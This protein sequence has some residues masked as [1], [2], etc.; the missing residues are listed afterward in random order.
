MTLTL[1]EAIG[2]VPHW[3]AAKAIKTTPLGGGITNRNYRV[4]VDGESFV[5][6]I[7]GARTEMLGINRDDE[8]S[9]NLT[10][11]KLGIAPEVIYF[12]Q[13]EGYLVTRFIPGRPIPPDEIRQPENIHKV[14]TI[15]QRIHQMPPITGKFDAFRI[16]ENYTQIARKY[17]VSFPANFDGLISEM[18]RAEKALLRRPYTPTP[19]HNDLLNENFLLQDSKIYLLDWEYAGMGDIY[20]DLANFSVN[21][22]L[23]DEQDRWLLHCYS[24]EV[25]DARW[26][27]LKIM[28]IMSDF[29]EAMWGMVQIGIS[30]LE[31]DFRGYADKH[32]SRLTKNIQNPL[33][34]KWLKEI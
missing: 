2:R 27:R 14:A 33:W 12:I 11:G 16:V 31:F 34:G 30:D 5:L 10:A 8:Y 7:V 6:R 24:G 1:E 26:A 22:S 20:F 18:N 13:P 9:A 21:H 19:C 28:K 23:T 15:L 25:N 29:R 32:F 17:Q 4:D 3:R